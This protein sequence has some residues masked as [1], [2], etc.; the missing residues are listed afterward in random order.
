MWFVLHKRH[1]QE[2]QV[3]FTPRI[4]PE[5]ATANQQVLNFI[6]TG[7]GTCDKRRDDRTRLKQVRMVAHFAKL[8]EAV[9]DAHVVAARQ[10]FARLGTR[11][12]VIVEKPLALRKTTRHDVLVFFGHFLLHIRL[13]S[14]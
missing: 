12:K 13:E 8:H 6:I 2:I 5:E 11:H 9:D 7:H 14:A 10:T 1:A 4:T 3:T